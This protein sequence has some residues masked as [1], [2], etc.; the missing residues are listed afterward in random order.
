[1]NSIILPGV[2]IGPNSIVAAGSVLTKNVEPNTVV[3]GNPA[4]QVCSTEEY[5]KKCLDN[6]PEYDE[7]A[8]KKDRKKEIL[9]MLE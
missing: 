5:A 3:A 8:Y 9:R 6:T 7:E 1:M 4:R 2:T